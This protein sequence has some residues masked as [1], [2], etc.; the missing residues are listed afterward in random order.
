M[1]I[2][3]LQ[4][5]VIY[6]RELQR[7][8]TKLFTLFFSVCTGFWGT[9]WSIFSVK[10][11]HVCHRLISLLSR[12]TVY[13]L[14]RMNDK[15]CPKKQ[16]TWASKS[17]GDRISSAPPVIS[18]WSQVS[19]QAGVYF[20]ATNDSGQQFTVFHIFPFC[21]HFINVDVLGGYNGTI[22]A[23]GQ[24]SSGKTHTMEVQYIAKW[25][26]RSTNLMIGGDMDRVE[27]F[28]FTTALWFTLIII[29]LHKPSAGTSLFHERL[30]GTGLFL[31]QYS[32]I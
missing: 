20:V 11:K 29:L 15:K 26:K 6:C 28:I 10:V 31:F 24:T 18:G 4:V 19:H 14:I 16:E 7:L 27:L 1:V 22:F 2:L 5:G 13:L 23:Y 30:W 9:A 8:F 12:G 17:V 32:Y 25:F 3:R 21:P